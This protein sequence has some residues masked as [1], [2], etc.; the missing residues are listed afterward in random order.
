MSF[1]CHGATKKSFYDTVWPQLMLPGSHK[2][3][4]KPTGNVWV[5]WDTNGVKNFLMTSSHSFTTKTLPDNMSGPEVWQIFK[6]LTVEKLDVFLP[7]IWTLLKIEKE[8]KTFF[9]YLFGLGTFDLSGKFGCPVLS[10][11]ENQMLRSEI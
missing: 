3:H 1:S 10:R 7:G 6:I 9:I 4:I 8:I 11:Q 5:N 2:Y